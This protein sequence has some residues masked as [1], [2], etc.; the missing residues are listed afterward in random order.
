MTVEHTVAIERLFRDAL[1][2]IAALRAERDLLREAC[3]E[4]DRQ[5]LEEFPD[6]PDAPATIRAI[7]PEGLA[8]WR[9]FRRA[10]SPTTEATR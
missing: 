9:Q 8:L 4:A 10:L 7:T 3:A 2:E 1:V 6:G 5:A